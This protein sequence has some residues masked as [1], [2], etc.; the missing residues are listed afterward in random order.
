M[1]I[2]HKTPYSTLL[3]SHFKNSN[4]IGNFVH[5]ELPLKTKLKNFQLKV[6]FF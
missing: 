3:D 2:S 5:P 6:V 1:L 4:D